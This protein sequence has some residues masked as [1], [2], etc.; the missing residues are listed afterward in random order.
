[1]KTILHTPDHDFEF[2]TREMTTLD[3][4]H[5]RRYRQEKLA[6]PHPDV[7]A[8]ILLVYFYS[9]LVNASSGDVP[10][11]EQFLGLS[12]TASN[13]WYTAV[14]DLNPGVLPRDTD[15]KPDEA[16]DLEKKEPPLTESSSG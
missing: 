9:T 11:E 5:A 10:N 16:A 2:E 12:G 13:I 4:M 3:H 15:E 8:Q 1:M 7:D 6:N 14:N